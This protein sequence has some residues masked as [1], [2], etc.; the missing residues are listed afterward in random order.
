MSRDSEK[1]ARIRSSITGLVGASKRQTLLGS[2]SREQVNG[3]GHTYI[4]VFLRQRQD[5]IMERDL[6][7]RHLLPLVPQLALSS[8]RSLGSRLRSRLS[9]G[10]LLR[11]SLPALH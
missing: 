11:L 8:S 2:K 3:L 9:S 1:K 6:L 10:L 4:Q 5:R 7:H